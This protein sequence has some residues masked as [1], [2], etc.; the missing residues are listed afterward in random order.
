[1][2]MPESECNDICPGES[3]EICGGGASVGAWRYSVYRRDV[4]ANT[5]TNSTTVIG[6]LNLSSS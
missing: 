5:T 6:T 3:S 2:P 1:M 4:A